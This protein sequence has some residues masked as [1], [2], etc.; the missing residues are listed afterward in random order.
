MDDK[1]I[2]GRG[3]CALE[4]LLNSPAACQWLREIVIR[5]EQG[6]FVLRAAGQGH[7]IEVQFSKWGSRIRGSGTCSSHEECERTV[8]ELLGIEGF[9]DEPAPVA[10]RG[11]GEVM[12]EARRV[13]VRGFEAP[14]GG[15]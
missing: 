8:Q 4:M 1:A 11:G 13:P 14:E 6:R 5:L 10:R 3:I 12:S 15:R 7:L 2:R 9:D